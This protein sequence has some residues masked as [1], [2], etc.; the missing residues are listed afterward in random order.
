MFCLLS[1]HSL[2][3]AGTAILRDPPLSNSDSGVFVSS[4]PAQPLLLSVTVGSMGRNSQGVSYM[5][6]VSLSCQLVHVLQQSF[7]VTVSCCLQ[8]SAV[9]H[10]HMHS[11]LSETLFLVKSG[12]ST[13]SHPSNHLSELIS[14]NSPTE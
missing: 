11:Q 9:I 1:D 2:Y 5:Y 14:S 6:F 8:Q 4:S 12:H 10:A 7:T 13:V 3:Q